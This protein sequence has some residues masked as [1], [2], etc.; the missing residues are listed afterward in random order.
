MADQSEL[1]VVSKRLPKVDA[2]AIVSGAPHYTGDMVPDGALY[3]KILRSPIAHG[4]IKR[5]VKDRAQDVPG[6]VMIHR[7]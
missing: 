7:R 2:E 3:A 1:R 5:I 4:R 6:V